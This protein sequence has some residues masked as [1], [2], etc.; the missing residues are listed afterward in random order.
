MF[1]SILL[2]L[3][4]TSCTKWE[5]PKNIE[6]SDGLNNPTKTTMICMDESITEEQFKSCVNVAEN[7]NP[8]KFKG[9]FKP[10]SISIFKHEGVTNLNMTCMCQNGFGVYDDVNIYM[11]LDNNYN[12]MY[13]STMVF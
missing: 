8:C 7:Q 5:C 2:S 1:A 13:D 9:S 11:K 6:I 12:E 3:S 10:K 4:I